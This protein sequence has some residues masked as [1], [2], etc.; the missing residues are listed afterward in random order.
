MTELLLSARLFLQPV[1]SDD[2]LGVLLALLDFG[3]V[4][5]EGAGEADISLR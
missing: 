4:L 3:E 1:L 5:A 2:F